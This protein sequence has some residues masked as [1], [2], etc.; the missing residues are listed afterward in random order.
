MR[1]YPGDSLIRW[2]VKKF[3]PLYIPKSGDIVPMD[4]R[5]VKLYKNMVEWSR[6]ESSV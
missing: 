6:K 4:R 1:A 3:G 2:T 5:T